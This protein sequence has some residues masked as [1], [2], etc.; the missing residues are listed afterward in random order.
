[1]LGVDWSLAANIAYG[2]QN[3]KLRH[4]AGKT[5]CHCATYHFLNRWCSMAISLTLR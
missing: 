2:I 5:G 1:M 3:L 4:Q